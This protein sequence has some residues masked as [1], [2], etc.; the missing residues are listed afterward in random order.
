M[1]N[2]VLFPNP[3]SKIRVS[4]EKILVNLKMVLKIDLQG[5]VQGHQWLP[6]FEFYN[7]CTSYFSLSPI[8]S[9]LFAWID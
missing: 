8:P 1:Q 7:F 2:F 3:G 6:P 5:Q 9:E 4:I